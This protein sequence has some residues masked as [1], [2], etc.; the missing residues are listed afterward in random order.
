MGITIIKDGSVSNI[1]K[2]EQKR[3][4]TKTF[5]CE[6]CGCLWKAEAEDIVYSTYAENDDSVKCP[7][8][9]YF[10]GKEYKPVDA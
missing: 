10:T 2:W 8:C 9:R 6:R 3:H 7:Q 5:L 1:D 4:P